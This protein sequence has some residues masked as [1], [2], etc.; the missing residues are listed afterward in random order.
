MK[1]SPEDT[2]NEE[3]HAIFSSRGHTLLKGIIFFGTPFK[4]SS[5]AR[6]GVGLATTFKIPLNTVHIMSLRVKDE[7]VKQTVADFVARAER[8]KMSLLIFFELKKTNVV[9]SRSQVSQV[10]CYIWFR[11]STKCR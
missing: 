3:Y 8:I 2:Y 7:D 1:T 9:V 4:G 10:C 6:K 11:G 5:S